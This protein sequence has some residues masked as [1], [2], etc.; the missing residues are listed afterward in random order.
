MSSEQPSTEEIKTS[1]EALEAKSP[2]DQ[3]QPAEAPLAD[4]AGESEVASSATMEEPQAAVAPASAP[5]TENSGAENSGASTPVEAKT[6]PK[7]RS[8]RKQNAKYN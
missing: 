5:T 1:E 2:A 4:K 6:S 7:R 8:L 3:D